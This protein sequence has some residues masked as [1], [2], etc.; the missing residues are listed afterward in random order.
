MHK[1]QPLK[2][3][4]AAAFPLGKACLQNVLLTQAAKVLLDV[5]DT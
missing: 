3:C 2:S 5:L 1:L 4:L